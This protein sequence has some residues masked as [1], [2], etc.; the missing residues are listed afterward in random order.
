M[1]VFKIS[2]FDIKVL[3]DKEIYKDMYFK[4][5][6]DR[7]DKVDRIKNDKGRKLSISAGFLLY[8]G[9]KQ[10]GIWDENIQITKGDKG[11]PYLK[12]YPNIN[13][14][15]SHSGD[16]AICAFS[17]YKI[18]ID[19]EKTDGYNLKIAKRFFTDREYNHIVNAKDSKEEFFRLW[20]LK[21]SFIKA[22][23]DGLS[24]PLNKF[25]F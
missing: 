7:R 19:I 14:S 15:L 8:E 21:E 25:E 10:Y 22:T 16:Y 24:L 12:N 11:K 20:V 3:E 2:I 13:Y 5:S 18:G 1:N 9:L 4:V 6:K 23:G 17:D